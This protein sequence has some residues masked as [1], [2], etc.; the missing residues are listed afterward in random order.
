MLRTALAAA[1]E[2]SAEWKT[3]AQMLLV[4]A[5]S[6]QGRSDEAAELLSRVPAASPAELLGLAE[7]LVAI[8]DR[9]PKKQRKA[10]AAL[11]VQAVDLLASQQPKLDKPEQLAIERV[12]AESLVELGT[13]DESLA[14]WQKLAQEHPDEGAVQERLAQLLSEGKDAGSQKAALE[15]WVEIQHKSRPGTPRWFHANYAVA[16]AELALGRK[17]QARQIIQLTAAKYADFGG[18]EMQAKFRKLLAKCEE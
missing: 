12:R 10:L 1:P 15:K 5:L 11:A 16:R 18:E 13:R 3:K 6:S 8:K 9:L 7:R 2:P 14:A 17:A 4:A